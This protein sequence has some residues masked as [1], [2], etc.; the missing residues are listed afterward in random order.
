MAVP[1]WSECAAVLERVEPTLGDLALRSIV[2]L[3]LAGFAAVAMRRASA[4]ARHWVWLLGFAGVVML[5]VLSASI[6]SWRVL[7]RWT[8]QAVES[9]SFE[10][11]VIVEFPDGPLAK[12]AGADPERSTPVAQAPNVAPADSV[13]ARAAETIPQTPSPM[14]PPAPARTSR[15]SPVVAAVSPGVAPASAIPPVASPTRTGISLSLSWTAWLVVAWFAGA[16]LVTAYVTLG[17]VSLWLLRR[18]CT[19]ITAGEWMDLLAKVRK[20]MRVRRS[21]HLLS[22]SFRAM[23]MTWGFWQ[24]RLLLPAEA[25]TWSQDQRR[26]VL[27]HELGHVRR[28]DCFAQLLAQIAC[29]IYWFNPIVWFAWRRMQMERELACDDLVLNTGAKATAYAEHLLHSASAMP[30]VRFVG[31]AVAMARPSTLEE[32]LRAILKGDRNR[33]ALSRGAA[34]ATLL[35]LMALLLPVAT[36]HAQETATPPGPDAPRIVPPAPRPPPPVEATIPATPAAETPTTS[37]PTAPTARGRGRG[38]VIQDETGFGGPVGGGFSRG[39]ARGADTPFGGPITSTTPTA[40]ADGP[41]VSFDATI[42]DVRIPIDQIGKIDGVVLAAEAAASA[43]DF[44]KALAKLGTA[45]PLYRANQSVRLAGDIISIGTQTPYVTNTQV[46]AS[47]QTINS[48]SYRS[49]GAIFS[50]A[51][52]AN[53]SPVVLTADPT[54]PRTFTNT[55]GPPGRMELDLSIQVSSLSEGTTAISST[56]KAPVFRNATMSHKGIV[57]ANQPFVVI[58]AD[59]ATVDNNGKAVAYIARVVVGAPQSSNPT[60]AAPR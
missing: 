21:V 27:L 37:V 23:P 54:R 51:G 55:S 56:V 15:Q 58:S 24:A 57:T 42:Y 29:A 40:V 22:C 6:P 9:P 3:A 7:P 5:P 35:L 20:E 11:G 10:A 48:I 4:A 36:L 43:A 13:A 14:P 28:N 17:Y 46:T 34:I 47:G 31:P 25:A 53:G 32:R 38:T 2:I 19:R 26:A 8:P 50:L 44:E 1:S 60:P 45:Q 12:Q 41:T 18:R 16:A 39:G 33:R 59:G 52:K 49:T 30:A